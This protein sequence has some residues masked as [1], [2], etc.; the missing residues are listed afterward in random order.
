VR[1][2]ASAILLDE[3]VAIRQELVQRRIQ[4]PD[5]DR[6]PCHRLEEPLEVRLLQ[7]QQLIERGAAGR[8]RPRP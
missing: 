1:R 3:L 8:P 2:R 5:G 7:R 6:K 4:Q